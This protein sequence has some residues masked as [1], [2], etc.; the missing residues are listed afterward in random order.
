MFVKSKLKF[1]AGYAR[2]ISSFT[3]DETVDGEVFGQDLSAA[4]ALR[5]TECVIAFC[6]FIYFN[7]NFLLM[8]AAAIWFAVSAKKINKK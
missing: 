4:Q 2:F 3:K 5:V 8:S 6:I 1:G 7:S